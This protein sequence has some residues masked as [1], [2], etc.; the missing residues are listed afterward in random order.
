MKIFVFVY[1]FFFVEHLRLY[2]LMPETNVHSFIRSFIHSFIHSFISVIRA[3]CFAVLWALSDIFPQS[4]CQQ[5][6]SN[7]R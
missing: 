4:K 1:F 6:R 7:E 3:C 2:K 5:S